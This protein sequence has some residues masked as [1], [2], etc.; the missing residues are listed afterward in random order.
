MPRISQNTYKTKQKVYQ[1]K[2]K[3]EK[4]VETCV[5]FGF[6]TIFLTFDLT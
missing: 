5:N 4:T 1:E 6:P 3:K 2:G